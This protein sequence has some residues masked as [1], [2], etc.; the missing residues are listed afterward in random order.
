[1]NKEQFLEEIRKKI[2]GLPQND[3]EKS[4]DYYSEM[5]DDCIEEGLTPEEAVA[6][7][8][9]PDEIAAQ[10]LSD[11]S[12]PKLIKEKVKPSKTLNTWQIL[13]I[14]LGSPIWF[15]LLIVAL[16][17]FITVYIV[18]W[19]LVIV[20]YAVDLTFAVCGI[21]MIA[22]GFIL[23]ATGRMPQGIFI[24]GTGL[25]LAGTAILLL[26]AFNKATGAVVKVSAKIILWVKSLF[27]KKEASE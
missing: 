11:I 18:L 27:V 17:V 14:I 24:T 12:L 7:M 6:A 9:T 3:I 5:I 4:L 23:M 13:L 22:A 2:N 16:S 20:M 21:A 26:F 10:I 19:A 15:A 25:I 1:M 8:G